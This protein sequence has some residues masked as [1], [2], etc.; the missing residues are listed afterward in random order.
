MGTSKSPFE[1][2]AKCGAA[3][4]AARSSAKLGTEAAALVTKR[5]ILARSPSFLRGVGKKGRKIGVRY[6]VTHGEAG[7]SAL[8]FATGP[9]QLIERD[10]KA[11]RIPRERGKKKRYVVIPGVG[12]RASA[13]HPGTKG[14]HPFEKG[15]AE[16]APL[17][18]RAYDAALMTELRRIF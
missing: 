9:F 17:A 6:Q 14:K 18:L 12:V 7:S 2:A 1:F 13:N 10:T 5:T 4:E 8:V 16:A 3:A 15:V 11:H